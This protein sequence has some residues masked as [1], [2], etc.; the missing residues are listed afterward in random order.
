MTLLSGN[1]TSLSDGAIGP[2]MVKR[3][4]AIDQSALTERK[5]GILTTSAFL[6]HD[7]AAFFELA[8]SEKKRRYSVMESQESTS[9]R[10]MVQNSLISQHLITHFPISLRMSEQA[11]KRMSECSGAQ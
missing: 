6:S 2:I 10:A 11:S 5:L 1:L 8:E 9:N 3:R 4:W 7:D